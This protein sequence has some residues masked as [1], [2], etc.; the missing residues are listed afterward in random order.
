V[1]ATHFQTTKRAT[2]QR[3]ELIKQSEGRNYVQQAAALS[4]VA[5]R[6]RCEAVLSDATAAGPVLHNLRDSRRSVPQQQV[7]RL[8][9]VKRIQ[10]GDSNEAQDA[11]S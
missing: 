1:Q 10:T 3:R 7:C 9:V 6:V 4:S 8:L 5:D 11:S 2:A